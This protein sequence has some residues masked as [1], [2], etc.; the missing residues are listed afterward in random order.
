MKVINEEI[1]KPLTALDK[2]YLSTYWNW[3]REIRDTHAIAR[4]ISLCNVLNAPPAL[5]NR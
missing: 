5:K 2:I 4:H 3:H 1:Y